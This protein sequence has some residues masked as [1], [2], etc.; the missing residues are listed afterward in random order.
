MGNRGFGRKPQKAVR[1]RFLFL[2]CCLLGFG[3]DF[4]FVFECAH[5]EFAAD[6]VFFR[7]VQSFSAYVVDCVLVD[8]ED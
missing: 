5:A 6:D 7:V 3:L 8:F 1:W 2:V 4:G